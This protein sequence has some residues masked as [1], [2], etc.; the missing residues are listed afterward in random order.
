MHEI[1]DAI[2]AAKNEMIAVRRNAV[3]DDE[4]WDSWI[5]RCKERHYLEH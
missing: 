1:I 4:D 5:E 2:E 3:Y